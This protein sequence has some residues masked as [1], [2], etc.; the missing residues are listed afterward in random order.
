MVNTYSI[1][2][3]AAA[4][5]A[6]TPSLAMEPIAQRDVAEYLNEMIAR[7]VS[8]YPLEVREPEFDFGGEL[9]ARADKD[10]DH[11][12]KKHGILHKLHIKHKSHK[13]KKGKS[14]KHKK[15]GKKHKKHSSKSAKKYRTTMKKLA[16]TCKSLKDSAKDECT[17]DFNAAKEFKVLKTD[18]AGKKDQRKEK[19]KKA[20]DALKKYRKT[21]KDQK[22]A[23]K[24]SKK[25][26]KHKR[27]YDDDLEARGFDDNLL[28]VLK[29]AYEDELAAREVLALNELD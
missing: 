27:S 24:K 8:D 13:H 20:S 6:A 22:K 19:M 26:S 18:K 1:V 17:K 29:R 14:H 10:K 7:D 4:I 12:K 9:V 16:K 2:F 21:L 28:W 25:D 15:G 11:K 23:A 3:A 5:L